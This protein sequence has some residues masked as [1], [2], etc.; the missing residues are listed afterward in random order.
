MP[1]RPWRASTLLLWVLAG[2]GAAALVYTGVRQARAPEGTA[3]SGAAAMRLPRFSGGS[4]TL[5]ELRGKVVMLDFW[6]TWCPPCVEEMPALLRLA[7][8]YE[9]RGLVFLAANRDDPEEAAT[10]I[11]EFTRERVPGLGPYVVYATDDL[12]SA[13][14]VVALPTL[15]FLDEKGQVHDAQRGMLSEEALRER[16]ERALKASGR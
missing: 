5:E 7:R 15:Y 14:E 16:I 2:M 10:L 6:A 1:R 3:T 8:E 13:F 11:E 4:V 12:M 9:S